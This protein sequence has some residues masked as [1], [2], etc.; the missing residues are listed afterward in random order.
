MI[1]QLDHQ[2][3]IIRGLDSHFGKS[4][5][6]LIKT[7]NFLHRIFKTLFFSVFQPETCDTIELAEV[8]VAHLGFKI[9]SLNGV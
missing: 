2:N 7:R 5:S 4:D 6:H 9:G 1:K 8:T 3:Q